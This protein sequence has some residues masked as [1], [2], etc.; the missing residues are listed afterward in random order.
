MTREDL[1]A[2]RERSKKA[3]LHSSLVNVWESW[4]DVPVLI[5]EVDRLT[6]ERDVAIADLRDCKNCRHCKKFRTDHLCPSVVPNPEA[7][8]CWEWRGVQEAANG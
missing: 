2:I 7:R 6:R 8:K 5:A 4:P 1:D 3:V